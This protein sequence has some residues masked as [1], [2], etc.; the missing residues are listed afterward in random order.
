MTSLANAV[1][2]AEVA[3]PIGSERHR[4][5]V[6]QGLGAVKAGNRLGDP[7]KAIREVGAASAP[8]LDAFT[9]P[10]GEDAKAVVFDLMQ[11]AGTGGRVINERGF[12]RT[13][14]ADRG[15]QPPTGRAG[16]PVWRWSQY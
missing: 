6:D 14:E 2:R 1:V 9:L 13:D 5:A 7:C 16:A 8:D 12:T 4:L 10:E 15:V 3:P 11:P